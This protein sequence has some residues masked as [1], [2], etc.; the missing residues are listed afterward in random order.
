M[1]GL[2]LRV[3]GNRG[4]P[5]SIIPEAFLLDGTALRRLAH[6]GALGFL[7]VELPGP[8]ARVRGSQDQFGHAEHCREQQDGSGSPGHFAPLSWWPLP[9]PEEH[10]KTSFKPN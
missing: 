7:D 8:D 3:Y 6:A 10:Q 2:G 4:G 5:D 1:A 9:T